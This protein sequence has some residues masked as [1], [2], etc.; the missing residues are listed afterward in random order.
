MQNDANILHARPPLGLDGMASAILA[1]SSPSANGRCLK[2]LSGPTISSG[3]LPR[4][5]HKTSGVQ[6][7]LRPVYCPLP[8]RHMASASPTQRRSLPRSCV[9]LAEE[10]RLSGR[11]FSKEKRVWWCFTSTPAQRPFVWLHLERL[12]YLRSL[13]CK[14]PS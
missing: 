1:P 3:A 11:I 14:G 13:V 2:I 12:R 9:R 5:H 8:S 10:R 6:S 4:R 7:E